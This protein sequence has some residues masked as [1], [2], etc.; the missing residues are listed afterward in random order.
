MA[1]TSARSQLRLEG[2]DDLNSIVHLLRMHGFDYREKFPDSP[3]ELPEFS[4]AGSVGALVNGI[5]T[6]VKLNT[7]RVVGFLLDADVSLIDR[8]KSIS[9]RLKQAG[10]AK[11]PKR[12]PA[13]GYVGESPRYQTRVGVWLMPDNQSAGRLE[14]FLRTLVAEADSLIGHAETATTAAKDLGAT[15]SDPDRI[16]AVLHTWLAWQDEPGRP[17][18]VAIKARYFRHDSP[19]AQAFV[20]WFKELYRL[21][22][23]G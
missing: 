23:P 21:D 5:E 1:Q 19:V 9:Q 6:A 16:K 12:P 3:P 7:G 18:G 10:V 2:V 4:H 13:D 11:L 17:Y 15:F 20:R 8:W 14:N 22:S